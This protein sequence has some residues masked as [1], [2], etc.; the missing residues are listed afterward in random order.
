MAGNPDASW[1]QDDP[2]SREPNSCP[3][4]VPNAADEPSGSAS[5]QRAVD[6][7]VEP[8]RQTV[9]ATLEPPARER[10][11]VDGAPSSTG[12]A[13][14]RHE[15]DIPADGDRSGV[16]SFETVR[17]ERP[18]HPS[19]FADG[20]PARA[21]SE[22]EAF[23]RCDLVDVRV[24]VDRR[25]PLVASVVG[26]QDP[27]DVDVDVEVVV[28]F[29]HRTRLGRPAPRRVPT[30]PALRPVERSDRLQTTT[31][32][33]EQASLGRTHEHVSVGCG[34]A[35]DSEPR[36]IGD[37]VPLGATRAPELGSVDGGPQLP[38]MRREGGH[39]TTRE[40]HGCRRSPVIERVE[41]LP[42]RHQHPQGSMFSP[43]DGG[44]DSGAWASE[45]SGMYPWWAGVP[46]SRGAW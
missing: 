30:G 36:E 5:K 19:I 7:V 39:G 27:A 16:R 28:P 32:D 9:A 35:G 21:R 3:S 43:L 8:L 11:S 23:G 25:G 34:D 41:P 29:R 31:G 14:R 42:R 46:R 45:M 2:V 44:V 17:P 1:V 4:D 10:S 15:H 13:R 22:H 18:R 33:A 6:V 40:L 24:D 37:V 20:E 12:S 38:S 26:P